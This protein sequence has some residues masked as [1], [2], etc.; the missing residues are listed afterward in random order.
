MLKNVTAW[1]QA[2]SD[3]RMDSRA[4]MACLFDLNISTAEEPMFRAAWNMATMTGQAG[5]VTE[6]IA[7][8]A[9]KESVSIV[10]WP[11]R[12]SHVIAYLAAL[13][14][15]RRAVSAVRHDLGR[16]FSRRFF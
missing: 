5:A 7:E 6:A 8:V 14:A 2:H 13:G 9:D 12:N 11:D 16:S 4:F 1:V 3:T 10:A 15:A